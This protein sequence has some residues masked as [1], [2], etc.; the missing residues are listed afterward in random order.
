M[1]A[2]RE[3]E[4]CGVIVG[5]KLREVV[6][7]GQIREQA[8]QDVG[9]VEIRELVAVESA[10]DRTRLKKTLDTVQDIAVRRV[11][12]SIAHAHAVVWCMRT[13]LTRGYAQCPPQALYFGLVHDDPFPRLLELGYYFSDCCYNFK[14]FFV[15][16]SD[17]IY[18]VRQ[19]W[20]TT[21]PEARLLYK[22]FQNY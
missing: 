14:L 13:R 7:I 12:D 8:V 9:A 6:I 22:I 16:V 21:D 10:K 2:Q 15:T 4:L 3:H 19:D 18:L 5:N 20:Q 1:R 11:D 17:I